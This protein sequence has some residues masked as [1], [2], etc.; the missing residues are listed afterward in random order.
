M[1]TINYVLF[2]I[3]FLVMG[4]VPASFAQIAFPTNR[5]VFQRGTDNAATV[6]IEGR[7]GSTAWVQARA[8]ALNG[9]NSTDWQPIA[10]NVSATY[11]GSIRL[12]GGW[13]RLEVRTASGQSW[14]V[15]KVGVGEVFVTAG[16]SN[17]YG[18]NWQQGAA[19]DDRVSVAHYWGG[20]AG[21]IDEPALPTSFVE[22]GLDPKAVGGTRSM[23][24]ASPLFMWGTFGD[25][26]VQKTGVPVMILGASMGGTSSANWRHS[27]EGGADI[28]AF[29]GTLNDNG[30]YRG[31]GLAILHYLKR[32]GV[33]A[34]L[35][36]QG[37][38]D[39]N[40]TSRETYIDNLRRVMDKSRSQLGGTVGWV[41]A[42]ASY[43][44]QMYNGGNPNETD[45]NIISAQQ[46]LGSMP[47]NWI[48]PYTDPY[49]FPDF[50]RNDRLHFDGADCEFLA[51]LWADRLDDNFFGSVQPFQPSRSALLTTGYVLPFQL[52]A[53]QTVNVPYMSTLPVDGSNTYRVEILSES[54]HV[55]GSLGQGTGNPISVSLP[56]WANGRYRLRVSSTSPAYTGEPSEV[57]TIGEGRGQVTVPTTPTTTTGLALLAPLYDCSSG[58]FTFQSNGTPGQVRYWGVGIANP[59]TSPGT[60]TVKPA[61]DAGKFTLNAQAVSGGPVVSYIWD[62]KGA[63]SGSNQTAPI[64]P[65]MPTAPTVP[66]TPMAPS[67]GL[68]LLA[69]LYDCA[70]RQFTFQSNA[71]SGSVQ[72][73]AAGITGRTIN[74]G[75]YAV[76]PEP[77]AQA[78]S[79]SGQLVMGGPVVNYSW[80]WKGACP[81]TTPT[82]PVVT[83]PT[84]P[85]TPTQPTTPTAPTIGL[86]LLAP[87]YNCSTGAFTFQSNV[88][89]GSVQFWAVGVT[90]RT[91]NAGPHTVKPAP[92]AG[93]FTLYAQSLSSGAV[94]SYEWNWKAGCGLARVASETAYLSLGVYPNPSAGEVTIEG[95]TAK[96]Q[97]IVLLGVDGRIRA[98]TGP[99]DLPYRLNLADQPAGLYLIRVYTT[100]GLRTLRVVRH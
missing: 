59:S 99:V 86:S 41:V 85:T 97:R 36:H 88:P 47:N 9:G 12:S 87:T 50:R 8:T 2:S 68:A 17:S 33:R 74:A 92:D 10:S 13:Y 56:S 25:R 83:Q 60:Y 35:W 44:P 43:F 79:L 94:V 98:Q 52:S 5:I 62:W 70:T 20:G 48:G 34:V 7:S 37:E 63:C 39:C 64:V 71:T 81:E 19:T 93:P 6:L 82:T 28:P 21:N 54:G 27:A 61:P 65:T 32:T 96:A 30:P 66:T 1:K 91:T 4:L 72:Y 100:S 49:R 45:P 26:I 80:D 55:L 16:Q 90:G 31:L 95:N 78:F 18:N 75:P 89:A 53:G 57:V 24:P 73:W 29:W 11:S 42:Q 46:A 14:S 69:P 51:G 67:T 22:A 76:K 77:D 38:S 3:V 58:A 23:A 15:D 84:N 40:S